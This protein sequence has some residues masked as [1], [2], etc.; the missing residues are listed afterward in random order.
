MLALLFAVQGIQLRK[1]PQAAMPLSLFLLSPPCVASYLLDTLC[2][3]ISCRSSPAHPML[4]LEHMGASLASPPPIYGS[5]LCLGRL[6]F[7]EDV[8]LLIE[9]PCAK[10]RL[11]AALLLTG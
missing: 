1:R 4:A 10:G 3:C 11:R 8:P 2:I 5:A 9:A 7:W 6:H